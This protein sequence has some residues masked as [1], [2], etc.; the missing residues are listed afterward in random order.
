MLLIFIVS[1]LVFYMRDMIKQKVI[2]TERESRIEVEPA[3]TLFSNLCLKSLLKE[4]YYLDSHTLHQHIKNAL[5]SHGYDEK[6]ADAFTNDIVKITCL[7]QTD[8]NDRFV[9]LHKSVQEFFAAFF[10]ST[11]Q[12][13]TI[14]SQIYAYLRKS[15]LS[16][17]KFDNLLQF[18][19]YLDNLTFLNEITLETFKSTEFEKYANLTYEEISVPF[20]KLLSDGGVYGESTLNDTFVTLTGYTS[21]GSI[22]KLDFLNVI[23]GD[24]RDNFDIDL[25]FRKITPDAIDKE[26]LSS[27]SYNK[28][29]SDQNKNRFIEERTDDNPRENY[30][31]NLKKFLIINGL[32]E[33]YKKVFFETIVDFNNE[34]YKVKQNEVREMK[35]AMVDSFGFIS[36]I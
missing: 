33:Y 31:F 3:R 26:N 18:L 36:E 6:L 12:E 5:K 32:Y 29:S 22:L 24:K 35:D 13:K 17:P 15:L 25:E 2:I 11:M 8:G 20:D 19:Y 10:I 4:Q 9:Y 1:Y 30:K 16:S 34:V 14:K 21:I 28:T 7:L 23:K 27:Y